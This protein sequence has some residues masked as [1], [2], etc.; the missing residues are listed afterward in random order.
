MPHSDMPSILIVDDH[1]VIRRGLRQ[2]FSFEGM[3]GARE[4]ASGKEALDALRDA[5]ADLVTLDISMD[6]MN[7]IELTQLIKQNYPD[8]R[9]LIVS[10]HNELTYVQ[11]AFEAGAD[12][13]VLKDHISDEVLLAIDTLL[14]GGRYLCPALQQ[15]HADSLAIS[16]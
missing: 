5:T 9:L 6:G 12:G 14:D 8:V 3:P 16:K 13:Y 1:P 10:M 2:L 15:R 7:G 4:A 11:E